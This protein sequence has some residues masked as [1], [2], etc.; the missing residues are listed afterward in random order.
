M[1]SISLSMTSI[2]GQFVIPT[3]AEL[4]I[5]NKVISGFEIQFSSNI[6]VTQCLT[7]II[8]PGKTY[9][10]NYVGDVTVRSWSELY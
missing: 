8:H 2:G 5:D 10:L 1:V 6:S 9:K 3:T 7:A 4:L